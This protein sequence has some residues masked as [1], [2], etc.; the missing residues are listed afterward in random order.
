MARLAGSVH[1]VVVQMANS[2]CLPARKPHFAARSDVAGKATYVEGTLM[3]SYST[4]ARARAVWS[5]T[6][7]KTG[8]FLRKSAPDFANFA[9][10]R[11]S[12]AS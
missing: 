1:G 6:H 3:S 12:W 8:R 5:Y 9:S 11:I 10:S 4:S 2:T 7:Q